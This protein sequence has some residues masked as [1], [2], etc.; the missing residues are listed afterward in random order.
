MDSSKSITL[1][2]K[3]TIDLVMD[4]L[5][6]ANGVYSIDLALHRPDGFNYDFWREICT[7]SIRNAVNTP[8]VIYLPHHW[9]IN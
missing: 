6:V 9:E 1:H 7:L 5:P 8:G 2:Q 4:A 3:G